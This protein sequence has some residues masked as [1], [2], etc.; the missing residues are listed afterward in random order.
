MAT[1]QIALGTSARRGLHVSRSVLIVVVAV[2]WSWLWWGAAI[3][4]GGVETMGGALAWLAGGFGPTVAVIATLRQS[5][6]EYRASFRKRLFQG[7]VPLVFWLAAGAF[8][9]MPKV[10]GLAIAGLAG[11]STHGESVT[12]AAIPITLIFPVI[13]VAIEEP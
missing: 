3:A 11:H 6:P 4:F 8:A 5:T 7:R 10:I 12:L 2:T 13:A 9:V 1:S